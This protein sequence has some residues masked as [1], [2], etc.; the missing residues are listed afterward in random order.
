[1]TILGALVLA[2]LS[3]AFVAYPFFKRGLRSGISIEDEKYRELYSKRN[4]TYAMLKEL[5]FDFQSGILTEEDFRELEARYR[6]K[7]ISI[8]RATDDLEKG[9]GAEGEIEDQ[10]QELRQGQGRFCTQCGQAFRESDRFCS[11]CGT[12]LNQGND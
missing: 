7:A 2:I 8:L 1:M 11:G 5:E 3:F 4:T 12:R 6:R 9:T 10:V